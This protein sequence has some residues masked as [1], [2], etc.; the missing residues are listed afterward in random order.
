ML[1]FIT[2]KDEGAFHR[3][4]LHPPIA[5]VNIEVVRS[6]LK[7][8]ANWF[9]LELAYERRIAH[10]PTQIDISANRTEHARE[11]ARSLPSGSEGGDRTAALAA[12]GPIVSITR[13][14]DRAAVTRLSGLDIRQQFV[15]QEPRVRITESV[16]FIAA[17]ETIQRCVAVRCFD[18]SGSDKD[19]DDNRQFLLLNEI[20]ENGWRRET[21]AVLLH[22]KTGR[23]VWFVLCWNVNPIIARG[24]GKNL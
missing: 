6:I 4:V 19:R 9:R 21:N 14:P 7:E 13:K 10:A 17:I 18:D 24:A 23:R 12:N 8:N 15:V 11:R 22:I 20:V 2:R 5:G 3:L 16:V 1:H